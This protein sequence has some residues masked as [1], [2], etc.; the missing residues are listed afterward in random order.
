MKND[1]YCYLVICF[2]IDRGIE[3]VCIQS[4][5]VLVLTFISMSLSVSV[6]VSVSDL[7]SVSVSVEMI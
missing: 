4:D 7:V 6:S 2:S 3:L 1:S 5:F